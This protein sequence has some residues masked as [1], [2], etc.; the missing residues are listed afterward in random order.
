MAEESARVAQRCQAAKDSRELLL[1]SC[2]L[3]K[4]PDAVFFLMKGV[5]LRTVSL[6]HNALTKIPAKLGVKF[7][8]IT[9]R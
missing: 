2:G 5:E 1:E 8:T 7:A 9:G 3:R 6:A 4:F